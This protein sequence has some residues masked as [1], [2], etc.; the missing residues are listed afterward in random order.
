MKAL[1]RSSELNGGC[2]EG[3]RVEPA[4]HENA[5]RTIGQTI[6]D[7][8]AEATRESGPRNRRCVCSREARRWEGP[9]PFR[10][11]AIRS[12]DQAVRHSK[13]LDRRE[14]RFGRVLILPHQQEVADGPIVQFIRNNRDLA[15]AVEG[16]ADQQALS[17]LRVEQRPDAKVIARRENAPP[18]RVPDHE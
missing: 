12:S 8:R 3:R 16:V 17:H 9:V 18:A 14:V 1:D 7:G 6:A 2:G 11:E 15:N 13:P 10:P 5:Q 4:A